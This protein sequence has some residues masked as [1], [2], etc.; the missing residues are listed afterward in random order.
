LILKFFDKG[1]YN[2][3]YLQELENRSYRC[4]YCNDQISSNKGLKLGEH[5]DGSG[6]QRGGLYICTNCNG[7]TFFNIDNV[8]FPSVAFGNSVQHLPKELESLYNEARRCSA[9]ACF[10]AA[11][12]LCRKALMNI[13]VSQGA[14]ENLRF[15]EYVNYLSENGYTPPNGKHWVDHIRKKG[16]EATHEIALMDE[17][18][19]KDLICFVEMLL[20]F[21]Y[22]FPASIPMPEHSA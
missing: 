6:K 21:I 17:A 4:G 8:R 22:E 10:T 19:A 16:N 12:L 20:K 2:W 3:Q 18:D 5:K 9:Q 14:K 15:I 7:P 11:V 13:A 1:R